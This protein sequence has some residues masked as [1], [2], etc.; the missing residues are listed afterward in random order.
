MKI[1]LVIPAYNEEKTITKTVLAYK[2]YF[3]SKKQNYEIIVVNDGSSDKTFSKIQ[4]IDGVICIS[5]DKNHGKG[6]A[7][8]RGMLR[9]TGDFVFFADA[10]LSY[11]PSNIDTALRVFKSSDANLVAGE[12]VD[13]REEYS[14]LRRFASYVLYLLIRYVLK[15][16][17][18]DSQCG[19]K[20][21]D[22]KTAREIFSKLE[23]NDFGFD[24]E[25][26]RIADTMGKKRQSIPVKFRHC[27][28]SK[29]KIISDS[30]KIMGRIISLAEFNKK[31]SMSP[32]KRQQTAFFAVFFLLAVFRFSYLG[33]NY[34]PYLD[35]Y[36]QY[37]L[38]PS[39]NKSWEN[40]L[41]GG[42]GVLFTRPLAGLA[43]FFIWSRFD[44]MPGVAVLVLSAL[45]ALSAVFFYK[46]LHDI[47]IRVTPAFLIFYT[48]FPINIEGTYWLSASSRIVV[49]MFLAALSCRLLVREKTVWFW[50]CNFVSMCFYEQTAIIAFI[51]PVIICM[52]NK[53]KQILSTTASVVN[54]SVLAVYYLYFAKM[55]NNSGRIGVTLSEIPER[56]RRIVAESHEMWGGAQLKLIANGFKRGFDRIITDGAF[57]WI[58][59]LI[60]LICVFLA[61]V[62]RKWYGQGDAMRKICVGLLLAVISMA[63]FL[64]SRGSINFRNAVPALLGVALMFDGMVSA[65]FKKAT[66]V[67]LGICVVCFIITTVS[68]V[69]DY[70]LTARRDMELALRAAENIPA[71]HEDNFEEVVCTCSAP[72]RFEQNSPFNDH[73]IS[74]RGSSWGITGAVRAMATKIK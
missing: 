39:I 60:V 46:T 32:E 55:S 17:T 4:N 24:F 68:E 21:F 27:G 31:T 53:K 49:S 56:I 54:L 13:K 69:C 52:L 70:D 74:I 10:D 29:V 66:P 11:E 38:Y 71:G 62:K 7:V 40:V 5:Y 26:L 22:K 58:L 35:D 47:N 9:A 61:L 57:L 1:S 65:F 30:V 63:P 20:G 72:V 67:I 73:I 64:V 48:F 34:T 6:Y 42:P 59:T 44:D 3:E 36:V 23:C 19:F 50:M 43:D 41:T 51:M 14:V 12:R 18:M 28:N 8:K 33:Y 25:V 2:N 45:Y 37:T 16:D 15:I